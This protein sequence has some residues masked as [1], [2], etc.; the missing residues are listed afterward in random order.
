MPLRSIWPRAWEFIRTFLVSL[1]HFHTFHIISRSKNW[2]AT[3]RSTADT[4]GPSSAARRGAIIWS[5][6]KWTA[7]ESGT[8]STD[9]IGNIQFVNVFD[10]L[11]DHIRS[12][13]D[14]PKMLQNF[15][16]MDR[17]HDLVLRGRYRI[18]FLVPHKG[19]GYSAT[20]AIQRQPME[21]ENHVKGRPL[22]HTS[23]VSW[24]AT[25]SNHT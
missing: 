9:P 8:R 10:M 14:V 22:N 24:P 25:S 17:C 16:A 13:F 6:R 15:M 23:C 2:T 1:N 7:T 11:S 21:V 3:P 18:S 19:S 5:H 20:N 4:H 12:R